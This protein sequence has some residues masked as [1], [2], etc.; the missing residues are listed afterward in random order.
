MLG[1]FPSEPERNYLPN[2][3]LILGG[4]EKGPVLSAPVYLRIH[5]P[6]ARGFR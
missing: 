6:P 1:L 2:T 3:P 4:R 5:P